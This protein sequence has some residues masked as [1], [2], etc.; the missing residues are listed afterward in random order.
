M[1]KKSKASKK[2][3]KNAS[4]SKSKSGVKNKSKSAK[5]SKKSS[6]KSKSKQ[7]ASLVAKLVAM[8]KKI[9]SDKSRLTKLRQGATPEPVGNYTFTQHDGS[10]ATLSSLF[11]AK[12]D[13]IL[14]HNMGKGCAYCTLWADGFNG[15]TPHLENRAAFVVVSKDD[16]E[17]QRRFYESRG[18]TFKMVSSFGTTFS[19]DLHFEDEKGHQM[20]GVSA[21]RKD[22]EGNVVRT[23]FTYFGPGDDF[24]ALWPMLDLLP[25]GSAGWGPRFAY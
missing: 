1:A 13:L 7:S 20:P 15:L 22:A 16:L 14:V 10:Q 6:S 17:T 12:Q 11:G 24:C 21:F 9:K 3:K 23:G 19:R 25:E 4:K 5:T 8:E 18:W 2:D